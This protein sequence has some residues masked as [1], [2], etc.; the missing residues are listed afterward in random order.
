MRIAAA[1]LRPV[2]L[3]KRLYAATYDRLGAAAERGEVGDRRAA[4]LADVA[5]D[6]L[7]L[8][9]GTGANLEHYGPDV[10]LVV[11]EPDTHMRRLLARKA[12]TA[13]LVAAVAERLPFRAGSFDAVVSTFVLCSVREPGKALAEVAR[14]LRPGGRLVVFEHVRVDGLTGRCQD[15][16]TPGTRLLCG[17]CHPNRRTVAAIA[18]A[19]FDVSGIQR[20]PAA[21][22][23]YP[24]VAGAVPLRW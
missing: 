20:V 21:A 23:L 5:G 12:P 8:G 15:L 16:I 13:S 24:L 6:V 17:N 18:A 9:G 11:T 3:A 1:T 22:A 7:E 10:R 19:G 4:L 2:G 14:V